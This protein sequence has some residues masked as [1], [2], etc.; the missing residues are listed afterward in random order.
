MMFASVIPPLRGTW[1]NTRGDGLAVPGGSMRPST[2]AKEAPQATGLDRDTHRLATGQ[3]IQ[4]AG[5]L[6]RLVA[7][8][9]VAEVGQLDQPDLVR[10]AEPAVGLAAVTSGQRILVAH[11]TIERRPQLDETSAADTPDRVVEV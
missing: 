5:Q 8:E 9:V 11:D 2:P 10:V 3:P 6:A 1:T 4:R 7:Q